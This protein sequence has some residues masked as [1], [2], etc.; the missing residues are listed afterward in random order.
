MIMKILIFIAILVIIYMVFFKKT[1]GKEKKIEG[2]AMVECEKCSTFVSDKEAIIKD[3]HF[4]CSKE[5][6]GVK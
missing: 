5:C 1:K 4:Y 6:A 2:E 3:G